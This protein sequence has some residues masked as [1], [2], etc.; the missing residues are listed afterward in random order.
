MPEIVGSANAGWRMGR[1]RQKSLAVPELDGAIADVDIGVEIS[2][3]RTYSMGGS[4]L[5]RERKLPAAVAA[6]EIGRAHV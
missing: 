4:D 6:G 2:R 1:A 3:T 5:L